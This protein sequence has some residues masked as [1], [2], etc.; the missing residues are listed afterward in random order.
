MAI[1]TLALW[2]PVV[3]ASSVPQTQKLSQVDY[4]VKAYDARLAMHEALDQVKQLLDSR[5]CNSGN[6]K[7]WDLQFCSAEKPKYDQMVDSN[8]KG[9]SEWCKEAAKAMGRNITVL[10]HIDKY[11]WCHDEIEWSKKT[12][13]GKA[14]HHLKSGLNHAHNA[15]KTAWLGAIVLKE[16]SFSIVKGTGN[17][18]Y[19]AA[20][21]V[22]SGLTSLAS[23]VA[24]LV[25]GMFHILT[26]P[27]TSLK[28]ASSTVASI[29]GGLRNA[30]GGLLSS[31]GSVIHKTTEG[32]GKAAGVV[33]AGL[34]AILSGIGSMM[35]GAY[36]LV[37]DP[38]GHLVKAKALVSS[39]F[40]SASQQLKGLLSNFTSL[41]GGV[42]KAITDYITSSSS[43]AFKSIRF[44]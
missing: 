40:T 5:S 34:G 22:G 13:I 7:G 4:L 37:S 6:Q 15:G 12:L 11:Q 23:G 26:N 8:N 28:T 10:E 42:I 1:I 35:T 44:R 2:A 30:V 21:S 9:V 24:S 29:A 38:L 18:L 20:G 32:L 14:Y 41:F 16:F 31:A 36:H 33:T 27:I 25:N 39:L 43:S 19:H 3:Y 17:G